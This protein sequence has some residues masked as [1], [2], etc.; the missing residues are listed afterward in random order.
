M[1][2]RIISHFPQDKVNFEMHLCVDR[3]M[4]FALKLRRVGGGV[5]VEDTICLQTNTKTS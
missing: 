3:G 4:Y 2:P 5:G 1:E